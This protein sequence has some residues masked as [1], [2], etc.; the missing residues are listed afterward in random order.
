MA[1]TLVKQAAAPV[2]TAQYAARIDHVSKSF[3]RPA[4]S[5]SYWTTSASTSRRASS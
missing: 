1:T 5:S 3:G 2:D 4:R